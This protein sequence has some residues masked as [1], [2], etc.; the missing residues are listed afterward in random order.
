MP[1]WINKNWN[2]WQ[3]HALYLKNALW[4]E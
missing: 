3:A 4:W 2:V 1:R